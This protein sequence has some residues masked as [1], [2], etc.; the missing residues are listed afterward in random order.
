M[1]LR[2]PNLLDAFQASAPEGKKAPVGQTPANAAGPFAA[3]EPHAA[4]S[5][6]APGRASRGFLARVASD[7]VVFFALVVCALGVGLAYYIGRL[8][9]GND[10]AHAAG[11]AADESSGAGTL[12]REGAP[13]P[14]ASPDPAE[15][16][17]K[18]A[19]LSG[20]AHDA[21]F[22]DPKYKFTVRVRQF[23]NDEAGTKASL[24]LRDYLRAEGLPVVQPLVC[25]R[26]IVVCVG[27][28]AEMQDIEQIRDYVR[29]LPGP[30]GSKK[31]P[32]GDAWID[33][34]SNVAAR[35]K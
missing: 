6:P 22:F 9:S 23:A 8:G 15:A 29:K 32:F 14:P 12:L 34:I 7:R 4:S 35:N 16:N 18:A 20:S 31:A 24:E 25:G 13:N 3:P 17:R 19:Q 1:V 26:W 11:G 10:G 28:K 30:K 2:K 27:Y 21:A 33:N 5:A